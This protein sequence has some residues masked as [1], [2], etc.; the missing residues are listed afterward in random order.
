[1]NNLE[2]CEPSSNIFIQRN[3]AQNNLY[4]IVK[5]L[6]FLVSA[7]L[8]FLIDQRMH[9]TILKCILITALILPII[10]LSRIIYLIFNTLK[11]VNREENGLNGSKS[12][13]SSFEI[14]L[15]DRLIIFLVICSFISL[16]IELCLF[17][18]LLR[19][20]GINH[21]DFWLT[22]TLL[23][24]SFV[25]ILCAIFNIQR[26]C[27][28]KNSSK[29]LFLILITIADFICIANSHLISYKLADQE[30]DILLTVDNYVNSNQITY[31]A[32]FAD[33][34]LDSHSSSD[35]EEMTES[36]KSE[37]KLIEGKI[38]QNISICEKTTK[39]IEKI[40]FKWNTEFENVRS[41]VSNFDMNF[42]FEALEKKAGRSTTYKLDQILKEINNSQYKAIEMKNEFCKLNVEN[43]TKYETTF[44][45]FGEMGE[46]A[47]SLSTKIEKCLMDLDQILNIYE[48]QSSTSKLTDSIQKIVNSYNCSLSK[49][50]LNSNEKC[51]CLEK[52]HQ[53]DSGFK[54]TGLFD[55]ATPS[56]NI[57]IERE[58]NSF[59]D[60]N[61]EMIYKDEINSF[62]LDENTLNNLKSTQSESKKPLMIPEYIDFILNNT[63]I[64]NLILILEDKIQ[65]TKEIETDYQK[66]LNLCRI[67][68]DLLKVESIRQIF[69]LFE[70]RNNAS[71]LLSATKDHQCFMNEVDNHLFQIKNEK[72]CHHFELLKQKYF[73]LFESLADLNNKFNEE[74]FRKYEQNLNLYNKINRCEESESSST[75]QKRNGLKLSFNWNCKKIVAPSLKNSSFSSSDEDVSSLDENKSKSVFLR[76]DLENQ[77][78]NGYSVIEKIRNTVDQQRRDYKSICDFNLK[79]ERFKHQFVTDLN[80]KIFFNLILERSQKFYKMLSLVDPVIEYFNETSDSE[81]LLSFTRNFLKVRESISET[82]TIFYTQL[83]EVKSDFSNLFESLS[84]LFSPDDIIISDLTKLILKLNQIVQIKHKL[85]SQVSEFISLLEN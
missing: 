27:Y 35:L 56:S 14:P 52:N 64:E 45:V 17:K 7:I 5:I 73:E 53:T 67:D 24:L 78:K 23:S 2:I 32:Q 70:F 72:W 66:T 50:F 43:M 68:C 18:N 22:I 39:K 47:T 51:K 13:F 38:Y 85:A 41:V 69:D 21:K 58:K 15:K 79:F 40:K 25:F 54:L 19:T 57:L 1:M 16:I 34:T 12:I 71:E 8:I 80:S 9:P 26:L 30:P 6:P 4:K 63:V 60:Q 44:T 49:S 10:K 75:E 65:L 37:I 31:F 55:E 62:K 61:T 20:T 84:H 46:R 33:Y 36:T 48:S 74:N 83:N 28:G 29:L 77:L 3:E 76:D 82:L 11:N 81:K 59:I 42:L